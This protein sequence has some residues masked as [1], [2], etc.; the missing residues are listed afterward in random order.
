MEVRSLEA[1]RISDEIV[2]GSPV[3]A[4]TRTRLQ[5][6]F[7]RVCSSI[8]LWTC[9]VQL[10]Q[11]V[12]CGTC[13]CLPESPAGFRAPLSLMSTKNFYLFQ[14]LLLSKFQENF[15]LE[16]TF[17]VFVALFGCQESERK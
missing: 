11:F 10:S 8:V 13:I 16:M 17:L 3:P 2:S 7:I 4:I 5:V 14:G 15:E 12:S 1:A 9:L 6:W